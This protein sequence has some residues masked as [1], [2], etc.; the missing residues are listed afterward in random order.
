MLTFTDTTIDYWFVSDLHLGHS[1]ILTFEQPRPFKT[2]DEHDETIIKN[3]N[4]V[5]K[6]KDIVF[7]LGD[8]FWKYSKDKIIYILFRLNGI[9]Y[10]T[11]GN[12]DR[13]KTV[14]I[15]EQ[16]MTHI[17]N[18]EMIQLLGKYIVLSHYPIESWQGMHRN[19]IHI[20]GHTHHLLNKDN[21]KNRFNVALEQINYT[22]IN[23]NDILKYLEKWK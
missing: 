13:N 14:T 3:W 9:K 1:N 11:R 15:Y 23:I 5:V 7:I 22:P 21:I 10:F 16:Y 6:E 2:I 8:I 18:T 17:E 20:H 19:T 4:S 12:H